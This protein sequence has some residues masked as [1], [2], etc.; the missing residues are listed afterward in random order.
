MDMIVFI[1]YIMDEIYKQ[2]VLNF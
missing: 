2:L 1:K